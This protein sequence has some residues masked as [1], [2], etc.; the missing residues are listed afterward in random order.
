LI[1]PAAGSG[2]GLLTCRRSLQRG[3]RGRTGAPLRSS[4]SPTQVLCGGIHG[5]YL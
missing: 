2:D 3:R 4:A 5:F 1:L